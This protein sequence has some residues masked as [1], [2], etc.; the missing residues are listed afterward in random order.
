M[1]PCISALTGGT[2]G[3]KR[4]IGAITGYTRDDLENRRHSGWSITRNRSAAGLDAH[5]RSPSEDHPEQ[6]AHPAARPAYMTPVNQ[7][8]ER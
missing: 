5:V 4:P 7:N 6:V 2:Q 3:A 8:T 1:R